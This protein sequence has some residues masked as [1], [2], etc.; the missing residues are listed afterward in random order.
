MREDFNVF[1]VGLVVGMLLTILFWTPH[2]MEESEYGDNM[3]LLLQAIQDGA[4]PTEN[5][6]YIIPVSEGTLIVSPAENPRKREPVY[7]FTLVEKGKNLVVITEE[8]SKN[9]PF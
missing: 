5:G 7:T 4:Q 8:E 9:I 6:V 2:L 1:L 3:E